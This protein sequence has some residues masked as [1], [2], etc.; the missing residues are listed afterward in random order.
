MMILRLKAMVGKVALTLQEVYQGDNR[1]QYLRAN[2]VEMVQFI[3]PNA[4]QVMKDPSA[5]HAQ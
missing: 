4:S 1:V 5:S 3:P 2:G